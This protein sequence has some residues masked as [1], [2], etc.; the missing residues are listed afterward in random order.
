[1]LWEIKIISDTITPYSKNIASYCDS[2]LTTFNTTYNDVDVIFTQ[3][4]VQYY[5]IVL[6]L[7]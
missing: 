5:N 3:Q 2:L 7:K 4:L 1:M 6:L